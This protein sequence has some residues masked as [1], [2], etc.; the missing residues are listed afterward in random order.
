MVTTNVGISYNFACTA[1]T[2][3]ILAPD[4]GLVSYLCV[5]YLHVVISQSTICGSTT[6]TQTTQHCSVSLTANDS[7]HGL[8]ALLAHIQKDFPNTTTATFH[9]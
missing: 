9:P 3:E 2:A 1:D 6:M 8:T 4:R 7:Q 5:S